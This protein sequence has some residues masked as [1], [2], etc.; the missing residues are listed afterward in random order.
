[1]S[2]YLVSGKF[3][4]ET[5]DKL[6]SSQE[7]VKDAPKYVLPAPRLFSDLKI[8]EAM[9]KEE[10]PTQFPIR[11]KR[12]AEVIYGFADASGG[13]LGSMF[14]GSDEESLV[15][16]IGVWSSTKSKEMSSN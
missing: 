12:V 4:E 8:L 13:G 5:H 3:S 1:M 9:F 15:I 6:L 2:H 16:R 14:Q 7:N 10:I 11:F